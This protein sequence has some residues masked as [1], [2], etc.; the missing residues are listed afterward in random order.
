MKQIPFFSPLRQWQ[1]IRQEALDAMTAILDSGQYIGGDMLANF[2]AQLARAI[3]V[4]HVMGCNSGT[5]ALWLALAALDLKKNDI[6]LTTPYSF[7]ASS[8]EIVAHQGH[9]VFI[10]IEKDTYNICPQKITSWLEKETIYKEGVTIHRRTGYPVRGLIAVNLFGQCAAYNELRTIAQK[11][12]LWIVED[13][14]QSLGAAIGEKKSG[15]FGDISCF[16]FYP[17]KNLGACGDGGAIA[18]NSE[19]LAKRIRMLAAHGRSGAYL[20]NCYGINSRL[21]GIQAAFLACKLPHLATY[22]ERRRAIAK[23]YYDAF[24]TLPYINLVQEKIGYHVFHQ[25]SITIADIRPNFCRDSLR[26]FLAENGIQTNI[27]YPQIF[28]DVSYLATHPDLVTSCPI[29]ESCSKTMLQLP[30]WPE[31]EHEEVTYIC[32]IVSRYIT[33][34]VSCDTNSRTNQKNTPVH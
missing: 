10:D 13:A 26:S 1:H 34:S 33:E 15:S 9:P 6:V 12:N 23:R 31:L 20:Y 28:T 19:P 21:D 18:T 3:K 5:D 25:Y 11:W 29:A 14:A 30:I 7:I 4:D 8:S 17:T 22:T 24:C 2:E 32:D 16:S 27:F